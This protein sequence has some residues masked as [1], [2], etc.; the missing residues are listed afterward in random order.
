MKEIY[1]TRDRSQDGLGKKHCFHCSIG[2]VKLAV[3]LCIKGWWV[4]YG[5]VYM[6]KPSIKLRNSISKQG[7]ILVF[8]AP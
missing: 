3:I 4:V 5:M 2:R 1:L 7:Q 6:Q 8:G